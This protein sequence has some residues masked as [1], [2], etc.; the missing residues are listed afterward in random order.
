M[1]A[2]VD[3][4]DAFLSDL[5]FALFDSFTSPIDFDQMKAQLRQL[6]RVS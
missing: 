1:W 5:P 3:A 2:S 4:A 6:S